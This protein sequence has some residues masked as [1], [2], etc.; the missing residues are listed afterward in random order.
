[1]NSK[2]IVRQIRENRCTEVITV[3]EHR[4]T[5]VI[6]LRSTATNISMNVDPMTLKMK[7]PTCGQPNKVLTGQHPSAT[8]Q[9]F[10][11]T[12]YYGT[13]LELFKV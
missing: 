7:L 11:L 6:W 8:K 13:K 3:S 1:M 2:E 9:S 12:S 10:H 5:S 4:Y